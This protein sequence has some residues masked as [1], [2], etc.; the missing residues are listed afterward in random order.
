M[1]VNFVDAIPVLSSISAHF[2]LFLTLPNS[3]KDHSVTLFEFGSNGQHHTVTRRGRRV[4]MVLYTVM[5]ILF[6]GRIRYQS[7]AINRYSYFWGWSTFMIFYDAALAG[8]S[9]STPISRLLFISCL[10]IWTSIWDTWSTDAWVRLSQHCY[11]VC[12][13][14]CE[15]CYRL[16]HYAKKVWSDA[17][18]NNGGRICWDRLIRRTSLFSGWAAV[19]RDLV[20]QWKVQSGIARS[21][22][23]KLLPIPVF[24]VHYQI[25]ASTTP[26][27]PPPMLLFEASLSSLWSIWECLVLGEPILVFGV[28]PAQTSQ[29]IWWLRDLLRPVSSYTRDPYILILV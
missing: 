23:M 16:T 14:T 28:S 20:L 4:G 7:V 25:L 19:D 2:Q 17:W 6:S 5:H 29:A 22:S 12:L 1:W 15:L 3:S 27:T 11:L 26:L 9:D 18:W 13:S 10:H 24:D 21:S 8:D